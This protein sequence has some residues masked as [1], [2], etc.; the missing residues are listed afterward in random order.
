MVASIHQPTGACARPL[1]HFR[2]SGRSCGK[3]RK[4][5]RKCLV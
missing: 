2:E 1:E 5:I 3:L 4:S